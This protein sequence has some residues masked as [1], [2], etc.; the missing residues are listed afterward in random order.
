MG[1]L[2][3]ALIMA[4]IL[5]WLGP[6]CARLP[7]DST[8]IAV[9]SKPA[10]APAPAAS[11]LNP[12]PIAEPLPQDPQVTV[13]TYRM[14][15]MFGQTQGK[16]LIYVL[17]SNRA[18]APAVDMRMT[19]VA[20]MKGTVVERVDGAPAQ[21]LAPGSTAYAGLSVSTVI[22]DELLTAPDEPGTALEWA[23]SYRLAGDVPGAR[24]CFQLRALPRHREPE[25][26]AWRTLGESHMCVPDTIVP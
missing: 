19:L 4:F 11:P 12:T 23:L 10:A 24:R 26:I 13:A 7:A 25:G 20:R 1:K 8:I 16:Y 2:F 21:T 18:E 3:A 14:K 5:A 9:P 17:R 15:K 6:M 22:I